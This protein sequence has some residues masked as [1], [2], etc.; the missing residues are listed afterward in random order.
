MRIVEGLGRV[1]ALAM[2]RANNEQ[3][4]EDLLCRERAARAEAER[5]SRMKDEFL[6]TLSH[7]LRTPPSCHP[8]LVAGPYAARQRGHHEGTRSHRTQRARSDAN[9]R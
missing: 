6:S 5:V 9:Y 4:R 2:E 3:Q 8:R 1:A 7:E